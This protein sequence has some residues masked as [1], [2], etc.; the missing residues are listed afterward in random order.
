MAYNIV[1]MSY[2]SICLRIIGHFAVLFENRKKP[3]FRWYPLK[4]RFSLW[5][6]RHCYLSANAGKIWVFCSAYRYIL[7]D[8]LQQLMAWCE[9]EYMHVIPNQV[10]NNFWLLCMV[11]DLFWWSHVCFPKKVPTGLGRCLSLI[12]NRHAAEF[13][14][15]LS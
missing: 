8:S 7:I 13:V 9:W 3:K 2:R 1:L 5:S 15:S 6:L 14:P 10:E 4:L 12:F 11:T